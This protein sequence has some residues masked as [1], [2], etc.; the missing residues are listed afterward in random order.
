MSVDKVDF[1]IGENESYLFITI[2]GEFEVDAFGFVE[3]D[4]FTRNN[5]RSVYTEFLESGILFKHHIS[6]RLS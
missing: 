4:G 5:F 6:V 2:G 1:I 3:S